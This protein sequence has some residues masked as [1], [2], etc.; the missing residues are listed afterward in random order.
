MESLRSRF[1]KIFPYAV[2]FIVSIIYFFILYGK[3]LPPGFGYLP[4]P[5]SDEIQFMFSPLNLVYVGLEGIM[6]YYPLRLIYAFTNFL[7]Y[8][9]LSSLNFALNFILAFMLVFVSIRYFLIKYFNASNFSATL[10]PISIDI[11]FQITYINYSFFPAFYLMTLTLYDYGLDFESLTFK[12]ALYRGLLLAFATTLSFDDPRSIF[13][14]SLTFIIFSFYFIIIKKNRIKYIKS[15][16]K[17]IIFGVGFLI[18]LNINTL[19][20]T[21]FTSSYISIVG[22]STVLNQLAMPL[23]WYYPIYTLI[24]TINWFGP[25]AYKA[26]YIFGILSASIAFIG[27]I[28]KK[29]ISLLFG[30]LLLGI[31]TFDF[32]GTRTINYWLAQTPYFGLLVY[33][34]VQYIP[35]YLYSAYFYSLFSFVLISIYNFFKNY[36]KPIR[37]SLLTLGLIFVVLLS[38][39]P[40]AYY[41][42]NAAE[43]S[44][45]YATV[46]LSQETKDVIRT[47]SNSTGITLVL[48]G[49]EDYCY[50]QL[51]LPFM[52]SPSGY[53]YMSF[54]WY[55]I[56]N[57]KNPAKALSHLG[58]E[59]I[60]VNSTGYSEYLKVLNNS[61]GF[62]Q[63]L[64]E[65]PMYVFKNLYYK[66]YI[67]NKGIW[68]AFNFPYVILNLSTLSENFSIVPFYYVNNLQDILPYVEGFIG[69]NVTPNDLIPMLVNSTYVISASNIYINQI[70]DTNGYNNYEVGWTRGDPFWT[71][72][73][74][75]SIVFGGS[76]NPLTLNV[77]LPNGYYYV[78][79]LQTFYTYSSAIIQSGG[80]TISSYNSTSTF[81]SNYNVYN[82][83][84]HF[85]GLLQ[86]KDHKITIKSNGGTGFV[87]I[88][89][90]P[91][92]LYPRLYNEAESILNHKSLINFDSDIYT[93]NNYSSK[94]YGVTVFA[95]PWILFISFTHLVTI[96]DKITSYYTYY[97]GVGET[98]VVNSNPNIILSYPIDWY[99][100][101]ISFFT[102]ILLLIVLLKNRRF[103]YI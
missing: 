103:L 36:K 16:G 1:P 64:H 33:F 51:Y 68:V 61:Q 26:N 49:G 37:R 39:I 95:N 27:I 30:I 24:M 21:K 50:Y 87:K 90:V 46:P 96:K 69:L 92:D 48:S 102:D 57:S 3:D 66:P 88:V 101:L 29:K 20:I 56:L 11:P 42:P 86:I 41:E 25:L 5:K 38:I 55:S 72:D 82:L 52:T 78:Y 94:D 12:Q 8:S 35:G 59:Y 89:F 7:S 43:L 17:M 85:A 4:L 65:G 77:N 47:V 6:I 45:A 60:V 18:L 22:D 80:F 62:D 28:S 32:I 81:V 98:F 10:I 58:V 15:F 44:K 40:I 79:I 100:P 34:Y 23:T 73:V 54:I 71:P 31:I 67:V 83:S 74:L 84:W 14:V 99:L 53:G 2:A 70:Q 97:F 76:G 9:T 63:I 19:I 13:Y 91:K 93:V 75:N